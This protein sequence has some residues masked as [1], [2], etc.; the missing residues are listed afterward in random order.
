MSDDDDEDNLARMIRE[1][2]REWQTAR[3]WRDKPVGERRT[4]IEVL[5]EARP[6]R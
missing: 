5:T 3:Y 1:N 4:V 6:W 2:T